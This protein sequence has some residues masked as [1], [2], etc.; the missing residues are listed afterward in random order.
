M[1]G[2]A[3]DRCHRCRCIKLGAKSFTEQSR[4]IPLGKLAEWDRECDLCHTLAHLAGIEGFGETE[5]VPQWEDDVLEWDVDGEVAYCIVPFNTLT[6]FENSP[7]AELRDWGS[8]VSY[9]VV[10][11]ANTVDG[12]EEEL[13]NCVR[14][15]GWLSQEALEK[16]PV[17]GSAVLLGTHL[18]PAVISAELFTC[19]SSHEGCF[20]GFLRECMEPI[21]LVN[22][23]TRRIVERLNEEPYLTLSY[24]Y[25]AAIEDLD[26]HR[27]GEPLRRPLPP[28]M[29]DT[30]QLTLELGY[31]FLWVDRYCISQASDP[32]SLR[33]RR[34]Q[35]GQMDQIYTRSDMTI[36][37]ADGVQ[38]LSGVTDRRPSQKIHISGIGYVLCPPTP[39][40][41]IENSECSER[42]WCYQEGILSTRR[43]IILK[44]QF[45][46]KCNTSHY[47]EGL[48]GRL[49]P[50]GN[51]QLST[52]HRLSD[53]SDEI[54][55]EPIRRWNEFEVFNGIS[56]A[57]PDP[58]D[59]VYNHIAEYTKRRLTAS[60]DILNAIAGTFAQLKQMYPDMAVVSGVPILPRTVFERSS[61]LDRF[62]TSL[63]WKTVFI[64]ERRPDFPSWSWTGWSKYDLAESTE[65]GKLER[66]MNRQ[67]L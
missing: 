20:H 33:L 13:F 31:N 46:L 50:A 44:D 45:Y 39:R 16:Y 26:R 27:V 60:E 57:R 5:D 11:E 30:M 55:L 32:E 18:D 37:A 42:A 41:E 54:A 25:S 29:E 35:I 22:C 23:T 10:E 21:K 66:G 52:S 15:R 40:F 12:Y 61:K 53:D 43:L 1:F 9:A 14:G 8:A 38:G 58:L 36:I 64:C 65:E 59:H 28:L 24:V 56:S 47:M 34:L 6:L 19:K 62:I 51:L 7:S 63:C 48:V 17:A 3:Q 2:R 49:K 67:I 4:T